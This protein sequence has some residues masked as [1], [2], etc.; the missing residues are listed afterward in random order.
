MATD[1]RKDPELIEECLAGDGEAWASLIDRYRGLIY[2]VP[3]RFRFP[4]DLADE[5]FQRTCVSLFESLPN[6]RDVSRLAAFLATTAA[7]HCR[8]LLRRDRKRV[9]GNPEDFE[10]AGEESVADRLVRIEDAAI[11]AA[12]ME[13]LDTKCRVLIDLLFFSPG[14]ITYQEISERLGIPVGS[15]GP[16]RGRCLE[17]LKRH[18][19]ELG[20]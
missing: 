5:V 14:G 2:S 10:S 13:R 11:L 20:F 18:L 15:I 8:M 3:I 7:N 9:P 19:L 4:E 17:K 6:V 16:T 1:P 12:A